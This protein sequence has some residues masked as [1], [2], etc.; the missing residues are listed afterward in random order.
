MVLFFVEEVMGRDGLD[1]VFGRGG[2]G[3]GGGV[4]GAFV[5]KGRE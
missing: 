5:E 3:C 4:D 2:G 1:I